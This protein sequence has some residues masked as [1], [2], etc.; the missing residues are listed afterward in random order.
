MIHLSE[1]GYHAGRLFC[2]GTKSE[3]D[4]SAHGMYSPLHLANFRE[5]CCQKCLK[6]WADEAY[7]EGD[8]MPD[9]VVS[10]RASVVV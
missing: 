8:E 4:V 6:V 1:T 10:M 3:A 9:W 7:D 2:L 5:K